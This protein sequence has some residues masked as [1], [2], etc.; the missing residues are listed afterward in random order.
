[1][2]NDKIVIALSNESVYKTESVYRTTISEIDINNYDKIIAV[3]S[4]E[5][6]NESTEIDTVCKFTN[7]RRLDINISSYKIID[8]IAN[9]QKLTMF[10]QHN[11]MDGYCFKGNFSIYNNNM[12]IFNDH[13]NIVIP[14]NITSLNM[15]CVY[16]DDLYSNNHLISNLP[17]NL[18]YLQISFR[19]KN[20]EKIIKNTLTNLPC[21]LKKINFVPCISPPHLKYDYNKKDT[22]ELINKYGKIPFGC[23]LNVIPDEL[24]CCRDRYENFYIEEPGKLFYNL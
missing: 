24:A 2:R 10:E 19:A 12:I 3:D 17:H 13:Q 9:L 4:N 22:Y 7:L 21:S 6:N 1:M 23:E 15:L 5:L 16:N 20:E 8:N 14:E 11:G 18:E